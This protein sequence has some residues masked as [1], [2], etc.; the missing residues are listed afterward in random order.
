MY[1]FSASFKNQLDLFETSLPFAG[2][3]D[4]ENRWI[5][6]SELINWNEFERIYSKLFSKLGR[7]AIKARIVVGALI[8]KHKLELSDREIAQ[9]LAE[10]PYLQIFIGLTEFTTT[11]PFDSSTLTNVRKR[12][13]ENEFD[14]FEKEIIKELTDKKLIKAKGL[15]VDATVVESEITFPTDCGLLNK[16]RQYLTEKIKDFSKIT[17]EKVRTY[18]RVARQEYLN[19]N[20]KRK[21]TNKQI[22]RMQK[23]LL[24]YVRR[25][26]KQMKEV[27]VRLKES[28]VEIPN[29]ILDKFEVA[30]KIY[31]QQKTMYEQKVKTI[32]SRIVSFHK[33]YVRPMVRGKAGKNVEF[34][35][36]V[37]LGY[38]DGYLFVDHYSTDSFNESKYLKQAVDNYKERFNKK[39]NYVAMDNIYGNR[40]NR[41]Y[42]KDEEIRTSVKALGRKKS[43]PANDKDR[44]WRHG[45]QRERNRIEGAIGHVKSKY[46]LEKVRAKLPKTEY[47]WF[48]LAL[49]SHNL[50]TAAK[51]A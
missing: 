50:V 14:K 22:R 18:C 5:K 43:N 20:K 32:K 26:I 47:S 9:Q 28:G 24:Q 48:R 8:L 33:H 16:V 42:L 35:P 30:K 37:S 36:K 10:H 34:G 19:F 31:E 3:L 21:K 11:P 46:L 41:N 44:R 45:K 7:S 23:S 51:R 29:K 6:L 49:L 39:P 25:N 2:R 12:L 4:R 13:G 27:M 40:D 15:L 17:G 1:E 38:V